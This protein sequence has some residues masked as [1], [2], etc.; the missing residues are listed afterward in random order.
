MYLLEII[1]SK[2]CRAK[3]VKKNVL[4]TCLCYFNYQNNF[5]LLFSGGKV[6]FLESRRRLNESFSVRLKCNTPTL[7]IYFKV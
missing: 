5:V 4:N 3:I 2:N 1:L 7:G 6:C